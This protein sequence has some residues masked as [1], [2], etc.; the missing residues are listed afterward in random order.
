M[1]RALEKFRANRH[2]TALLRAYLYA[3][4]IAGMVAGALLIAL[5]KRGIVSTGDTT[6]FWGEFIMLVSFGVAWLTASKL[7]I[8]DNTARG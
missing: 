4:C 6:V 3:S 8:S 7:I 2:K 1:K 5:Y